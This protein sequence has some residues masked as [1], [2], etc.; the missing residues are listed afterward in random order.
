[1]KYDES[2]RRYGVEQKSLSKTR[3]SALLQSKIGLK[4]KS[5]INNNFN[6]KRPGRPANPRFAFRLNWSHFNPNDFPN[7]EIP[8]KDQLTKHHRYYVEQHLKLLKYILVR[9]IERID[10]VQLVNE[11]LKDDLKFEQFFDRQLQI[12]LKQNLHEG[13]LNYT[14]QLI[15][16]KQVI[17]ELQMQKEHKKLNA[18]NFKQLLERHS[19]SLYELSEETFTLSNSREEYLSFLINPFEHA[20]KVLAHDLPFKPKANLKLKTDLNV[21]C[22]KTSW[23]FLATSLQ[24]GKRLQVELAFDFGKMKYQFLDDFDLTSSKVSPTNHQLNVILTLF[25]LFGF[26]VVIWVSNSVNNVPS[27]Y[28]FSTEKSLNLFD[29]DQS[30]RKLCIWIYTSIPYRIVLC[31]LI[32]FEFICF[33]ALPFE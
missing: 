13:A 14:D 9:K 31:I 4:L 20:N 18:I 1:M 12:I 11:A 25:F 23:P 26:E 3:L 28:R 16:L 29:Y 6:V 33:S 10:N 5:K 30:P 2:K 8:I 32:L 15:C 21:L 27:F 19:K 7:L 17:K 24:Y 22:R